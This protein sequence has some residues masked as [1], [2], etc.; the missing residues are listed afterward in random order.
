VFAIEIGYGLLPLADAKQGGD[1]LSRVTGVR[2][3]LARE[4]G[5]LVPPVSVRDNLELEPMSTVS[6]CVAK[7]SPKDWCNRAA[8]WP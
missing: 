3:T 2:K 4:K 6:S 7:P 8:A 1:L 5:L